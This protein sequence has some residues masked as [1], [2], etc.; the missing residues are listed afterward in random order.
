MKVEFEWATYPRLQERLF[1]EKTLAIYNK[2]QNIC[3]P[4]QDSMHW[5]RRFEYPWILE[6]MDNTGNI[7]DVGAGA[8]ALQFVLADTGRFVTSVDIDQSAIDWVNCRLGGK[9]LYGIKNPHCINASLP[10]LPFIDGEFKTIT[11]I[12]VLEHLPKDQVIPSIRELIRI[13]NKEVFITMD[14]CLGDN[15]R[16]TDIK[17]FSRITKDE[18]GFVC[19]YPGRDAIT[20]KIGQEFVVACMRLYH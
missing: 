9:F 3:T 2:E 6:K 8:T 15:P 5:T 11:C 14:I 13:S 4:I 19:P 10:K 18:L 1:F 16:Q 20:F 17:D 7:L 12:S